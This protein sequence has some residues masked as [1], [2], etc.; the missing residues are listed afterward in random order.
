MDLQPSLHS[1]DNYRPWCAHICAFDI[2]TRAHIQHIY[3]HTL[4]HLLTS[5]RLPCRGPYRLIDGDSRVG[6][7]IHRAE[8]K[9][10]VPQ[11]VSKWESR[12][13]AVLVR[14]RLHRETMAP[15]NLCMRARVCVCERAR[16]NEKQHPRS[17]RIVYTGYWMGAGNSLQLE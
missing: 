3:A 13:V 1:A 7:P 6:N 8:D 15:A 11:C 12:R 16:A 10:H 5:D 4:T 2:T 17:S 14:L 9:F